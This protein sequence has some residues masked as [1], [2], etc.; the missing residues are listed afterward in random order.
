M[1]PFSVIGATPTNTP[2]TVG[3]VINQLPAEVVRMGA[4]PAEQPLSLPPALL[5]N[6]LRSGQAALP[7]F[8]LYRVC[9]ALFQVPISPPGPTARGAACGQASGADRPSTRKPGRSP[10]RSIGAIAFLARPAGRCRTSARWLPLSD[11]AFPGSIAFFHGCGLQWLAL[12][13]PSNAQGTRVCWLAFL[14]GRQHQ[15][16][17][18]L[19]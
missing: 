4:L 6:A 18:L 7:V 2:L 9:P 12:Q 13:H 16:L 11:G 3:D 10:V 1:S 8:E 19:C 14:H 15:R 17:S 5:E